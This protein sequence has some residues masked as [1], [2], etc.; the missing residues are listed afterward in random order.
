MIILIEKLNYVR[1]EKDLI[2][3]FREGIEGYFVVCCILEYML[4]R[5][6]IEILF[7]REIGDCVFFSVV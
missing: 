2:V 3:S 5:Y 6:W 4:S 1:D 7:V